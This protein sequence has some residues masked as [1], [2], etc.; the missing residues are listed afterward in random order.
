MPDNE[1]SSLIQRFVA[2]VGH[3]L[4]WG[5]AEHLAAQPPYRDGPEDADGFTAT[6]RRIFD[7]N[8]EFMDARA[9]IISIAP[10][11]AAELKRAGHEAKGVLLIAHCADCGGGRAA[12][13]A[14]W[15]RVKIDL[16][17]IALT[18]STDA[19]GK[20]SHNK[21]SGTRRSKLKKNGRP[22]LSEPERQ[23]RFDHYQ[24]WL[25]RKEGIR[26]IT[27]AEVAVDLAMTERDLRRDINWAQKHHR[28]G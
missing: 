3:Y 12:V 17:D 22:P 18:E 1:V 27:V 7:A 21:S 14:N 2:A 4:R 24:A 16:Q 19:P 25:K 15:V 11:L 23:K 5:Q 8:N 9:R 10:V 6:G 13:V 26:G 28:E 20:D